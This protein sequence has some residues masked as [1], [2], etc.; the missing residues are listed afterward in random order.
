MQGA[1][2][3]HRSGGHQGVS[4]LLQR[5][6]HCAKIRY[7]SRRQR[8]RGDALHGQRR[9]HDS[10]QAA[11][12]WQRPA[13]RRAA[14]GLRVPRRA[15]LP[16]HLPEASSSRHCDQLRGRRRARACPWRHR[17]P[18]GHGSDEGGNGDV[19][20]RGLERAHAPLR[21]RRCSLPQHQPPG[22]ECHV[23]GV[24]RPALHLR[25]PERASR[26][27]AALRRRCHSPPPP[28]AAHGVRLRVRGCAAPGR[29]RG[30]ARAHRRTREATVRHM[31]PPWFSQHPRTARSPEYF[32]AGGGVR[33]QGG[34]VRAMPPR[35]LLQLR[36]AGG[37]GAGSRRRLLPRLPPLRGQDQAH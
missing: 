14:D 33:G 34:G 16:L 10:R 31:P 20:G 7:C 8:Q 30:L 26:G 19:Q 24:R 36:D 13:V 27:R 3:Q 35:H 2:Q 4:E 23:R 28:P 9:L 11:R 5:A 6:R 32:G 29:V 18:P 22:A 21:R 25:R 17:H 37:A 15:V 1:E 12:V